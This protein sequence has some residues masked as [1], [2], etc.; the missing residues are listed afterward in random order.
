MDEMPGPRPPSSVYSDDCTP[1]PRPPS[2][3]YSEDCSPAPRPTSS[4]DW[5]M[6]SLIYQVSEMYQAQQLSAIK[7]LKVENQALRKSVIQS[8]R[9]WREF[10]RLVTK[11]KEGITHF[12]KAVD[13]YEVQIAKAQ[14]D[15]LGFW[16]I[17]PGTSE[18]SNWI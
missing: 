17:Y 18:L 3:V 13:S 11:A 16:G 8:R 1:A 14:R 4:G 12:E 6:E 9:L 2:S 15:W 7:R 5:I 10:A